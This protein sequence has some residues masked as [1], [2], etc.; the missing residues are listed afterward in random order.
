M[1]VICAGAVDI[2][3]V[4]GHPFFNG[5]QWDGL[6]QSSAPAFTP[7]P[8]ESL[9]MEGLDWELNSML[10]DQPLIYE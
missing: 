10:S 6:R 2:S 8:P 1:F 4:K 9:E 3:E 5:L 7:P